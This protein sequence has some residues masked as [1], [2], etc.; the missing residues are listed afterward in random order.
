MSDENKQLKVTTALIQSI[1]MAA[2][3]QPP[4]ERDAFIK[5]KI[6]DIRQ[7]LATH[8]GVDPASAGTESFV[9]LLYEQVQQM[10]ALLEKAGGETEGNA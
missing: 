3:E 8:Q 6:E 2:L 4:S 1:A 5:F 7:M 9:D 10:A